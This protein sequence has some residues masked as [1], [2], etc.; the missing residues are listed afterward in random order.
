MLLLQSVPIVN[1][2]CNIHLHLFRS[3]VPGVEVDLAEEAAALFE[4]QV[5]DRVRG[6]EERLVVT[7][8]VFHDVF[9]FHHAL[10]PVLHVLFHHVEVEAG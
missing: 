10:P 1:F 2:I 4:L 6:F 9:G 7:E 3:G 5:E 8:D